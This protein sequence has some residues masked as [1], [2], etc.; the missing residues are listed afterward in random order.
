MDYLWVNE[1]FLIF[2][3]QN[4]DITR[5]RSAFRTNSSPRSSTKNTQASR[6]GRAGIYV[7]ILLTVMTFCWIW[8]IVLFIYDFSLHRHS[9]EK[10][11]NKL[12]DHNCSGSEV[13]M[14]L[15]DGFPK[16]RWVYSRILSINVSVKKTN[17]IP[18]CRLNSFLFEISKEIKLCVAIVRRNC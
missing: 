8:F 11:T 4:L 15:K 13:L 3:M 6:Q 9:G 18:G 12:K 10:I 16:I 14:E 7:L 2:F 17:L 1:T 5:F